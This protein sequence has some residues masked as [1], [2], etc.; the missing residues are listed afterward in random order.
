MCVCD[1]GQKMF[2]AVWFDAFNA[3][4]ACPFLNIQQPMLVTRMSKTVDVL[5]LQT[6]EFVDLEI[7][8]S[9][10]YCSLHPT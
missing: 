5:M 7:S 2:K 1:I 6:P 3:F 9:K 8:I 10:R 4:V